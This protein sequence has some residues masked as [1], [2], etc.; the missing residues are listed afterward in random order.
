MVALRI[1]REPCAYVRVCAFQ[2]VERAC[3][4][5]S[6]SHPCACAAD[7][8]RHETWMVCAEARSRRFLDGQSSME[9]PGEMDGPCSLSPKCEA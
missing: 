8:R 7:W 3:V 4:R 2:T 9:E 1:T 6:V 5:E